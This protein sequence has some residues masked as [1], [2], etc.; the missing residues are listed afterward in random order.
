MKSLWF[1]DLNCC[2]SNKFEKGS[3]F[4][5]VFLCERAEIS[6]VGAS[7]KMEAEWDKKKIKV[8]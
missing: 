4:E 2:Y 1:T 3:L 5:W 6:E 7:S 8:N